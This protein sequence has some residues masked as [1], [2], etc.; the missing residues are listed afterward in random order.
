MSRLSVSAARGWGRRAVFAAVVP[1]IVFCSTVTGAPSAA[2]GTSNAVARALAQDVGHYWASV[3]SPIVDID[4]RLTDVALVQPSVNAS[5][6][7]ILQY[8]AQA[9]RV[10]QRISP[11]AGLIGPG[12]FTNASKSPSGWIHVFN[13][14]ATRPA[15]SVY[16]SAADHW[17]GLV[18]GK[19]TSRWEI[20][21]FQ[22]HGRGVLPYPVFHSPSDITTAVDNCV[23]DCATG[24][25]TVRLFR[26]DSAKSSFVQVGPVRSMGGYTTTTSPTK[27]PTLGSPTASYCQGCGQVEPSDINMEGDPTSMVSNIRWESWGGPQATGIGTGW[28]VG[29]NQS[30]AQG[31][32]EPAT[33]V[34]F[35][36]GNCGSTYGYQAVAWYFPQYGETFNP[37]NGYYNTCTGEGVGL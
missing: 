25:F 32:H 24:T 26:F 18:V 4:H 14:G 31:S 10:E 11:D 30:V 2:A 34:A 17:N 23:P 37:S 33:V 5:T 28:Y 29:P 16:L 19:L 3:T 13:L 22:V 9:W 6:I 8:K 1:L 15:F 21:P 36:L 20:V 7:E 35:N 27:Q 12:H